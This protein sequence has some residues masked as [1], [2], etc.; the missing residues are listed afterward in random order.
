MLFS[1]SAQERQY[2]QIDRRLKAVLRYIDGFVKAMGYGAGITITSL[3]R[4]D[5]EGSRHQKGCAADISI[6]IFDGNLEQI[7]FLERLVKWSPSLKRLKVYLKVHLKGTA[8]HIHMSV[9]PKE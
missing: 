5:D 4:P 3:I 6:R 9:P 8:P 2:K 7:L 1:S